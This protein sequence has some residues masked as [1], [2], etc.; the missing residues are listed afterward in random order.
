MR[1]GMGNAVRRGPQPVAQQGQ[2][3]G[4]DLGRVLLQMF[5]A[6][7]FARLRDP[8]GDCAGRAARFAAVL[9]D[10]GQRI[11]GVL[12]GDKRRGARDASHQ[13]QA[14]GKAHPGKRRD[15]GMIRAQQACHLRGRD[16]DDHAGGGKVGVAHAQLPPPCHRLHPRHQRVLP[17]VKPCAQSLGQRRH[18]GGAH[19]M[20]ATHAVCPRRDRPLGG[21]VA[22]QGGKAVVPRRHILRAVV[23]LHPLGPPRGDT[24]ADAAPFVEDK[25]RHP[26]LRQPAGTGQPGDSGADHHNRGHAATS[27]ARICGICCLTLKNP[28]EAWGQIVLSHSRRHSASTMPFASRYGVASSIQSIRG[29]FVM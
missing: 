16:G 15:Q 17:H 19:A 29:P 3:Q 22:Q 24:P 20:A 28:A 23:E 10:P 13:R 18:A 2:H 26:R 9:R 27:R 1:G 7:G 8:G 21:K 4:G 12:S 14:G 25:G 11:I 6:E 5:N